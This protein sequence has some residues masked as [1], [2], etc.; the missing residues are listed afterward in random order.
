MSCLTIKLNRVWLMCC[1]KSKLML[2]VAVFALSS[3]NS[4]FA[5]IDFSEF[6]KAVGSDQLIG[7][8]DKHD[9]DDSDDGDCDDFSPDTQTKICHIPRGN[10]E[11]A[12]TICVSNK[13][14]DKH[15]NKHCSKDDPAICDKAGPCVGLSGYNKSKQYQLGEY[16]LSVFS[17]NPKLCNFP[18]SSASCSD[19]D[20]KD[21]DRKNA[22]KINIITTYEC[23][24][25]P[26]GKLPKDVYPLERVDLVKAIAGTQNINVQP[27]IEIDSKS[28]VT[29]CVFDSCNACA[30]KRLTTGNVALLLHLVPDKKGKK[31]KGKSEVTDRC[32]STVVDRDELISGEN[33]TFKCFCDQE[34]TKDTVPKPVVNNLISKESSNVLARALSSLWTW[35]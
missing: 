28:A 7:R 13:R 35:R 27:F 17:D 14:V 25:P 19:P 18:D 23:Q 26:C 2:F 5:N 10:I 11:K 1:Q 33:I 8:G 29:R 3:S 24:S 4:S 30:D 32:I 31:G 21:F 22:I 34:I 16:S 15:L 9:H 20:S 12:H 6:Y